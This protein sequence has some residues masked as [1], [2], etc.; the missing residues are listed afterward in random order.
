M[1]SATYTVSLNNARK[2]RNYLFPE[3]LFVVLVAK[4]ALVVCFLRKAIS[5]QFKGP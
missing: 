3:F 5:L 1:Y 4:A 2:V